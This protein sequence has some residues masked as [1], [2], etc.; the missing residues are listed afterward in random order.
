MK[1][2]LI[3]AYIC[4][5]LDGQ[6]TVL[7]DFSICLGINNWMETSKKQKNKKKKLSFKKIEKNLKTHSRNQTTLELSKDVGCS[8]STGQI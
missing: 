3:K 5:S 4:R 7:A 2:L 1:K 8:H 6:N